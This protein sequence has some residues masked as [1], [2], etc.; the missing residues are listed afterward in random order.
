MLK[1]N[2]HFLTVR[3]TTSKRA[4]TDAKRGRAF[5]IVARSAIIHD[6]HSYEGFPNFTRNFKIIEQ[7]SIRNK[8]KRIRR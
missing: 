3:D 8:T 2:I 7:N 6:H 5:T 4:E 1:V